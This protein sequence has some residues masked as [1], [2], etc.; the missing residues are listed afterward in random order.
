MADSVFL[1][2]IKNY[3]FPNFEVACLI[4][5]NGTGMAKRICGKR[6]Y[7]FET[8]IDYYSR[9]C[10]RL[11]HETASNTEIDNLRKQV[12]N[13]AFCNLDVFKNVARMEVAGKLPQSLRMECENLT[14]ADFNL[15]LR[16]NFPFLKKVRKY[17]VKPIHS[18]KIAKRGLIRREFPLS[19]QMRLQS[20]FCA[21][22]FGAGQG[23]LVEMTLTFHRDVLVSDAQICLKV[24]CQ[25]LK[26]HYNCCGI[27]KKEFQARGV[28]HYHLMVKFF[29]DVKLGLYWN[30]YKGML[31]AGKRV[32]LTGQ[33]HGRTAFLPVLGVDAGFKG[34][35]FAVQNEWYKV[36][37]RFDWCTKSVFDA[38]VEVELVK[39]LNS[40]G[41]Y[42]AKYVADGD[43]KIE[44]NRCPADKEN[45]GRWWGYI[46]RKVVRPTESNAY[47]NFDELVL[48]ARIWRNYVMAHSDKLG[49]TC[50]KYVFLMDVNRRNLNRYICLL[51]K[52]LIAYSKLE[53][54]AYGET[55]GLMSSVNP[56][57]GVEFD[58]EFMIVRPQLY[59]DSPKCAFIALTDYWAGRCRASHAEVKRMEDLM[60]R[61]KI[62]ARLGFRK[63][64]EK[65]V[66]FRNEDYKRK[67]G[68]LG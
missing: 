46:N 68:Y 67:W 38:G 31:N 47:I 11:P 25:W 40:L 54:C 18:Q 60:N 63:Q 3:G 28:V 43:S 64:A 24:F 55:I 36:L 35:R 20:A 9:L 57:G 44:Q 32:K 42:F 34:L 21:F 61:K 14:D 30:Y 50:P 27:W 17:Q 51:C 56:D 5:H 12:M 15:H 4:E 29:D 39:D 59:W 16:G 41:A 7:S 23:K 65:L 45:Q 37:S 10:N 19:S 66:E 52:K 33:K 49:S 8:D 62:L 26:R 58:D 53:G 48:L 13:D 1:P 6:R 2:S 22:D